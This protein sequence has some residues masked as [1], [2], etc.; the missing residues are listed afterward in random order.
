[1]AEESVGDLGVTW[2]S[3]DVAADGTY[4]VTVSIG[5]RA[6]T[7]DRD[8]VLAYVLSLVRTA[9]AAAHDSAVIN[10]FTAR[11][12]LPKE[13]AATFVA[14]ELRPD[15]PEPDDEATYPLRFRPGV[16]ERGPF[17]HLYL[18]GRDEP[19]GQWDPADAHGHA[20]HVLE[21]LATADLD[22]A[23]LRH[24]RGIA[25]VSEDSARA[26]IADLANYR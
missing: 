21:A 19:I 4:I 3:S 5:D 26:M 6:R 12:G 14:L 24:L 10:L 15:R 8:G 13:T 23:L 7:L 17:L 18:D 9:S 2:V 11:L 25:Q 22:A 1:M 20:R 16:G